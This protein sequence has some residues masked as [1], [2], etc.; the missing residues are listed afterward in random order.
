VTKRKATWLLALV[1][2]LV[3]GMWRPVALA[4]EAP[5]S[6]VVHD[7]IVDSTGLRDYLDYLQE[8]TSAYRAGL[9]ADR[10]ALYGVLKWLTGLVTFLFALVGS[11]F[12]FFYGREL[13]TLRQ[14]MREQADLTVY[15]AV[16]E[17]VQPLKARVQ[18][19]S[20]TIERELSY[21]DSKVLL[22]C[23]NDERKAE[24]EAH[25][26]HQLRARGLQVDVI[27][28]GQ[29]DDVR[30]LGSRSFVVLDYRPDETGRDSLLR[31]LVEALR[32]LDCVVPLVVYFPRRVEGE[33][34]ELL[35]GYYWYTFANS[36]P[37]LVGHVF[38]LTHAFAPSEG[39][40][41]A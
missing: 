12:V 24:L 29:L 30:V 5:D 10:Q 40:S 4:Q 16:S 8:E 23:H 31:T 17:M 22:V 27:T 18:A 11:L 15:V 21:R 20:A 33:D 36:S 6:Q 7:D 1:L 19:L 9:E 28:G 26:A 32:T 39:G 34:L 13:R 41:R 37:T 35:R 38:T 3:C 25:E 2:T 14:H